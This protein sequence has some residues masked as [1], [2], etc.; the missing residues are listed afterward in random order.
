MVAAAGPQLAQRIIDA[1]VPAK[2]APAEEG[3]LSWVCGF[4][5]T[6]KAQNI[7]TPPTR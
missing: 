2:W 3:T 6:S 1:G 4:A 5:L 7:P